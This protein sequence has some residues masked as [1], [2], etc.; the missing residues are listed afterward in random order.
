MINRCLRE[1]PSSPSSPT[2]CEMERERRPIRLSSSYSENFRGGS[3]L[4]ASALDSSKVTSISMCG[5]ADAEITRS[6]GETIGFAAG[7]SDAALATTE[8][9]CLVAKLYPHTPQNTVW[10]SSRSVLQIGQF[11]RD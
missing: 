10:G 2:V 7:G 6:G 8:P 5:A 11:S 1:T 9:P 4:G 3:P